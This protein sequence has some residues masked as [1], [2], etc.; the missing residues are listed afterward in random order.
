[1]YHITAYSSKWVSEFVLDILAYE[2]PQ[3][4]FLQKWY[5]S[6]HC[7]TIYKVVWG[8][9]G[10][11]ALICAT[12]VLQVTTGSPYS[13]HWENISL[14]KGIAKTA[15]QKWK[16]QYQPSSHRVVRPF[17]CYEKNYSYMHVPKS[18]PYF[19]FNR[20]FSD[21]GLFVYMQGRVND[22]ANWPQKQ[23]ITNCYTVRMY[24]VTSFLLI[25]FLRFNLRW[26]FIK[27]GK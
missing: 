12:Q 22:L 9:I 10:F 2:R 24:R 6:M 14:N 4:A 18:W 5:V 3:E 25:W 15:H 27:N 19:R 26:R 7:I 8:C 16:C 13:V 11:N 1:M 23:D 21:E 20:R 17:R